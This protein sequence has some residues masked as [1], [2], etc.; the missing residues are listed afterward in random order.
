MKWSVLV[1]VLAMVLVM[2]APDPCH[3][4]DWDD[5]ITLII[6]KLAGLWHEGE[7]KFMGHSCRY[8]YKPT[9]YR[10]KMYYK[11]KMWCPGWVPFSGHSRTE[12]RSGA[13]EHAT[14]DFVKQAL[15]KNLFTAEEASAWIKN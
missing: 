5:T 15:E 13:I 4:Q 6:N 3:G 7:A 8:S 9:F 14:R 10:W 2:E 1:V 12:S 11:G